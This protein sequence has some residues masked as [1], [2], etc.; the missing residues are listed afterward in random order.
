MNDSLSSNR[1]RSA[2][3][4][5]ESER[6]QRPRQDGGADKTAVAQ[7]CHCTPKTWWQGWTRDDVQTFVCCYQKEM[8]GVK[9]AN[10]GLDRDA[11][12][13]LQNQEL[14]RLV[15][16]DVVGHYKKLMMSKVKKQKPKEEKVRKNPKRHTQRRQ[17]SK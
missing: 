11:L 16:R 8:Q 13:N 1:K 10:P 2:S 12:F 9:E 3:P 4:G 14:M 17:D 15:K 7:E 5:R 6:Q